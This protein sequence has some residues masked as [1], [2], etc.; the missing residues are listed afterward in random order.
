MFD[1]ENERQM[2]KENRIHLFEKI[3]QIPECIPKGWKKKLCQ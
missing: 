1:L 2:Y 3:K